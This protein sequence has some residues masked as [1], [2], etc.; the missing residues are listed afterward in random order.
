VHENRPIGFSRHRSQAISGLAV[1]GITTLAVLAVGMDRLLR[2]GAF[3]IRELRLEGAFA[4]IDPSEIQQAVVDELGGNYFSLDLARIEQVVEALPWVRQAR[5]R[6]SWPHGLT[7]IIEE[8]QPV[9]RWGKD[10]W[11]N[12][13]SEIVRLGDDVAVE[14]LVSLSGP[15]G[16]A[17]DVWHRYNEWAPMLRK[18]DLDLVS[19][20]VDNRYAWS[21]TIKTAGAPVSTKVLLGTGGHDGRIARLIRSYSRLPGQI[22]APLV[23]DMRYPNGMAITQRNGDESNELALNE[24]DQ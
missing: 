10:G 22:G 18:V 19:I 6:R 4:N 7:V 5:V 8:Q 14:G 17:A 13:Q 23:M 12:H 15:D 3:P 2:P 21:L 20:A 11:I 9:A 1:A 16:V 24:V